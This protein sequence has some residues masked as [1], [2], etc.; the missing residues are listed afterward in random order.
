MDS[1]QVKQTH[2]NFREIAEGY[3]EQEQDG[4]SERAEEKV[5]GIISFDGVHGGRG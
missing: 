3:S 2:T 5:R 4:D 1:D